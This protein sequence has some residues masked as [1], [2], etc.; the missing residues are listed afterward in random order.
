MVWFKTRVKNSRTKKL[1]SEFFG[2]DGL[3]LTQEQARGLITDAI[4]EFSKSIRCSQ[5]IIFET[6]KSQREQIINEN[7][8]KK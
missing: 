8:R 6:Q 1:A 5:V 7:Y 4:K 3:G 2:K